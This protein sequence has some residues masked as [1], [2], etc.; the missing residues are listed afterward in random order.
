MWKTAPTIKSKDIVGYQNV[1]VV[2][3]RMLADYYE[4][5]P[6]TVRQNFNNNKKWFIEGE[7]YFRLEGE[8]L[9]NFRLSVEKIDAQRDKKGEKALVILTSFQVEQGIF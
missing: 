3:T 9:K 7:S 1:A 4:T 6:Q 5:E 2:T 8:D